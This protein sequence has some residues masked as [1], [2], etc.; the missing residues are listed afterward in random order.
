MNHWDLIFLVVVAQ[1][2]EK[3]IKTQTAKE[4]TLHSYSR[5]QAEGKHT[6]WT[7]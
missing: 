5:I 7:N 3:E 1:V 2:C 6:S 4:N